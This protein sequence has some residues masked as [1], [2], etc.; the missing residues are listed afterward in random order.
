[1][2]RGIIALAAIVAVI[3]GIVFLGQAKQ[4]S[5]QS[6][7]NPVPSPEVQPGNSIQPSAAP[8]LFPIKIV[9]ECEEPTEITPEPDKISIEKTHA[10][11]EGFVI[12][13]LKCNG[14]KLMEVH[15][16][17]LGTVMRYLEIPDGWI[18]TCYKES[19]GIAGALPGKLSYVFETP[20]DD[21]FYVFLRAKWMDACGN[22]VWVKID[23]GEWYNLE[24]EYGKVSDKNYKWAWHPL[25]LGGRMKPYKLTQGKHTLWLN[26]REDG[27][28]LDQWL[29]STEA[30]APVGD[31]ALHK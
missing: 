27:P 15:Q 11:F 18:D 25:Y 4:V 22:S 24:D 23:D 8:P 1:M 28:C 16:V 2:G 20:R 12:K 14:T 30:S 29:V 19:K 6:G 3:G 10:G 7:E 5:P 13:S 26:T 21:T 31:A 17:S 9:M